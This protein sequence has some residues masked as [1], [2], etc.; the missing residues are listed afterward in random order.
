VAARA[1]SY[2]LVI[3]ALFKL[4]LPIAVQ[5]AILIGRHVYPP[6]LQKRRLLLFRAL[7]SGSLRYGDL[8]LFSALSGYEFA[9][10]IDATHLKG[11]AVSLQYMFIPAVG[12]YKGTT[13]TV[14]NNPVINQWISAH[15]A[16]HLLTS[17][18]VTH[19]ERCL[20]KEPRPG[21]CR[22]TYDHNER[23][24]ELLIRH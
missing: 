4:K 11:W 16:I 22:F 12:V 24:S 3:E 8:F 13:G 1:I 2:W 21:H 20:V 14:E 15:S 7:F 23:Q 10:Q 17:Y 6:L 5:T 18:D 9:I 19:D